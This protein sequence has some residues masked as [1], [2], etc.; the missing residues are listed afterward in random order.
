MT[1]PVLLHLGSDIGWY[2]LEF[3]YYGITAILLA[4]AAWLIISGRRDRRAAPPQS[5]E[6]DDL[7]QPN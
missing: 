4:I 7:E 3:A 1:T 5:R 6:V 2:T